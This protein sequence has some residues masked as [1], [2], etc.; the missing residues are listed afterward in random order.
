M[1][2]NYKDY[3]SLERI[4]YSSGMYTKVGQTWLKPLENNQHP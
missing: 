2:W 1:M 4:L 3:L